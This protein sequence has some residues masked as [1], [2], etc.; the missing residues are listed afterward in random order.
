[1]I[2]YELRQGVLVETARHT[3]VTRA[4]LDVGP[5]QITVDP[6]ELLALH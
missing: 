5:A 3:P 4:R 1:V 6:A 2:V